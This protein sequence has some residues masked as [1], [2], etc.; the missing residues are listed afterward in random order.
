M[1]QPA[2]KILKQLSMLQFAD[3]D[4]RAQFTKENGIKKLFEMNII[5]REW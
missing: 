1:L 4:F 5:D 2:V 3:F